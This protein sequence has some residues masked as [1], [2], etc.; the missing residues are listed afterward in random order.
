VL[1][2]CCLAAALSATLAP[3]S[4]GGGPAVSDGLIF[5]RPD[6]TTFSFP[7]AKVSCGKS[8]TGGKRRAIFVDSVPTSSDPDQ[9]YFTLEAI[10][11]DVAPR[12]VVR[13]PDPFVF[14]D[15]HGA[16]LFV[17][18]RDD[19]HVPGGNEAST[20]QEE[21]KGKIVFHRARCRPRPRISFTVHAK[22]GSEFF[23]VHRVGI[24]G[25]FRGHGG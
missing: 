22:I 2:A 23:G 24:D 12:G 13:F 21:S 4:S 14:G 18:D 5:S 7:E 17:F 16:H 3:R 19:P 20:S 10:I 9:A 15:P 1:T 25:S 6:G 11:A 8:R